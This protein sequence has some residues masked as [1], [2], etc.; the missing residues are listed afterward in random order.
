LPHPFISFSLAA[1]AITFWS[2]GT[3]PGLVALLL[4]YLALSA[5]FVPGKILGSSSEPYLAFYGIFGT[6]VS[7]FSTSRRRAERLL[8]EARDHLEA[9]VAE[10]T[11][12]LARA[13]EELQGTDAKLRH[14]KDRL[15][16][17]LDLNNSI[18]SKL[19]LR[20]LL[21][22][23]SASLRRLMQCDAVGVNLPDQE[24]GELKLFALDFPGAKGFLREEMP[25]TSGSLVSKAFITGE[26]VTFIIGQ[27][28][29]TVEADFGREGL[30]SACWLPLISRSRVLGVL[31][32]SRLQAIPFSQED[33]HFL[34]QV[35]TQ[36][37]IAVENALSYRQISQLSDKLAQEKLY[38]EDEIRSEANFEEIVGKSQALHRVLKLVETVAPT[39]STVLI[40]G[41]TGTGKELIARAIHDLSSR[42]SNTFVRLNCAALPAGLLESELFGHERGAFTGAIAQRIGRLELAN[43]GTIFLDE[44]GEIPLELQPKL[45]RVLQER[46]FERLGS[47]R[48]IRT[49]V[50]LIAATNR[51]LAAM[52]QEQKFRA[53]LFFRLNV[54]PV[55]LP[56]LRD[57][58]E[59]IP[60]LVR[61]FA[62]EF[63]RRMGRR[64]EAISSQTM[65]AL[66]QY[67]WPG[68]IRELQNVIERSVILSSGPTLNLP[69]AEL[70][71]RTIPASTNKAP[72]P[73][74]ARRRPVRS[75]VAEVDRNQIIRALK[76]TGGRIG[77]PSGA[78]ASLGLKRTTFITRMRK[79][80]IHPNPVSQLEMDS[81]DTSDASDI[82][83][84][85]DSPSD[86]TSSD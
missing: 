58:P 35:A 63:S 72:Q 46:E 70:Q 81:T 27:D 30:Q 20:D 5:L 17:L 9:R 50:R 11:R 44:I 74:T 7:W 64:I 82:S 49:D 23:I 38:L 8:T 29:A 85:Q 60:L 42:S 53:D 19:D 48:T 40:F 69:V 84:V 54:F 14:E 6:A 21:R 16:L 61:H 86:I 37:A 41:E 75:I 15:K 80:G 78:A 62:E 4:S 57:R 31:G 68:N 32:L 1:I 43:H 52:V 79:L 18:V 73:H 3:G 83:T 36:V 51:D 39:H 77:G 24:T 67:R 65:N 45:L 26:P 76:E 12:E 71:S 22:D 34:T 25:R 33:V 55:E 59:D 2:A 13:N 66:R 28:V 47:T 56:P 10:R